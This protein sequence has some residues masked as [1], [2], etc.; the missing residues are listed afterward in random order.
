MAYFH[1]TG[2]ISDP[3]KIGPYRD[4]EMKIL[5]DLQAEGVVKHAYR[6]SQGPG[7]FLI[8]NASDL[9][10]AQRQLGRLPF[11]AQRLLTFDYTPI[12]QM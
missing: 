12:S 5:A 1:A 4:E 10:D 3:S 6:R 9:E 11:V 2:A 7:V 8:V